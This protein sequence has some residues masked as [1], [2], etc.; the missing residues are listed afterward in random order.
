M[1]KYL[2]LVVTC[3]FALLIQVT[4]Q[5]PDIKLPKPGSKENTAVVKHDNVTLHTHERKIEWVYEIAGAK[6][7]TVNMR[8]QVE[9]PQGMQIEGL[10]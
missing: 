1:E 9:Y 6:E 8:Y 2:L 7:E 10:V 5:E 3:I 4:L